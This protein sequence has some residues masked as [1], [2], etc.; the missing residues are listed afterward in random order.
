MASGHLLSKGLWRAHSHRMQAAQ[1]Q[2]QTAIHAANGSN[3][4]GSSSMRQQEELNVDPAA[5]NV[6][7]CTDASNSKMCKCCFC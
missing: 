3:D 7:M 6:S 2:I 5:F 1:Q 4:G